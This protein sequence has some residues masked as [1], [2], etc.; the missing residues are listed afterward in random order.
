MKKTIIIVLVGIFAC[1]KSPQDN[2]TLVEANKIHLEAIKIQEEIEDKIT[3]LDSLKN[4]INNPATILKIDSSK[5]LFEEWKESVLEVEGFEHE[6]HEH[7]H[8]HKETPK[9]SD[10]LMLDYQRNTQKA[11]IELNAEFE[12]LLKEIKP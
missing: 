8:H 2:S 3:T 9:M 4:T 11:I 10:E 12:K 1:S 6:E 7:H 5:K